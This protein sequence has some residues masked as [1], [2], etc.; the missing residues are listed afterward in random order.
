[1]LATLT[2]SDQRVHTQKLNAFFECDALGFSK[3]IYFPR[4]A[5]M[6][7]HSEGHEGEK[8]AKI[9]LNAYKGLR[10]PKQTPPNPI[11]PTP[12][13]PT[14]HYGRNHSLWSPTAQLSRIFLVT[15]DSENLRRLG[16]IRVQQGHPGKLWPGGNLGQTRGLARRLASTK[17][18][19][20]SRASGLLSNWRTSEY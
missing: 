18:M 9:N 2:V 15:N 11:K 16:A 12:S 3:R 8:I 1:M 17:C 20:G 7:A 13:N 5:E 14:T 6:I 19:H 10:K 4:L